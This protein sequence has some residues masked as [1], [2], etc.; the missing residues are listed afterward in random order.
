[1]KLIVASAITVLLSTIALYAADGFAV[2]ID[3][4]GL[5]KG[6]NAGNA[7]NTM[8]SLASLGRKLVGYDIVNNKATNERVLCADKCI[9]PKINIEGN[10]IAFYRK[11]SGGKWHLSL[12]NPDGSNQKDLLDLASKCYCIIAWPKGDWIYY[13]KPSSTKT[14]GTGEIWKVNVANASQN[15]KVWGCNE[16]VRFSLSADAD[17][18]AL[19]AWP[20]MN[21]NAYESFP[22]SDLNDG[23]AKPVGGSYEEIR[24]TELTISRCNIQVAPSGRWVFTYIHYNHM[25]VSIHKWDHTKNEVE[26]LKQGPG[27]GEQAAASGLPV[28]G[29]GSYIR[30]CSNSDKWYAEICGAYLTFDYGNVIVNWVDSQAISLGEYKMPG[31]F[32]VKPPAGKE[33]Q[34]QLENGS[35]YV[36]GSDKPVS[37]TKAPA[38]NAMQYKTSPM[39]IAPFTRNANSQQIQIRA[40]N[41]L[42]NLHGRLVRPIQK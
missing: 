12:I 23:A 30:S 22:P 4:T 27:R 37:R 10:R 36:V 8:D 29:K 34:I 33:G 35:W 41:G 9:Y 32:W 24:G 20:D 7:V 6:V 25:L 28:Q 42:V 19:R 16:I 1:M 40:E 26:L 21:N 11:D 5:K 3:L 39:L 17:N 2:S 13:I 38:R 14:T 31:D 18:A 15:S